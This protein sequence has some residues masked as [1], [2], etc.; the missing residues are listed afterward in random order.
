M[1]LRIWPQPLMSWPH[2]QNHQ[3]RQWPVARGTRSLPPSQKRWENRE[4]PP[5]IWWLKQGFP[6]D[7]SVNQPSDP[8][9]SWNA[10]TGCHGFEPFKIQTLSRL[11]WA[12]YGFCSASY[13]G[14]F[15]CHGI[16]SPVVSVH[17]IPS[18]SGLKRAGEPTNPT[19]WVQHVMEMP[20]T[21]E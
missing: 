13:I 1:P 17:R 8:S 7:F 6:T 18:C 11:D 15:S 14:E 16:S 2:R 10:I 3:A 12:Y 20:I 5:C 21:M 4:E 19:A 9:I